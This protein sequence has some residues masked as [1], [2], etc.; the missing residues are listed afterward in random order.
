MGYN[1]YLW[2]KE[3]RNDSES[4]GQLKISPLDE[5]PDSVFEVLIHYGAGHKCEIADKSP[6]NAVAK[7]LYSF[8]INYFSIIRIASTAG[9]NPDDGF[10][11]EVRKIS[12]KHSNIYGPTGFYFVRTIS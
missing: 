6:D 12:R 3:K 8:R 2:G 5:A 9:L 11:V 10:L 7:A 1:K 4:F